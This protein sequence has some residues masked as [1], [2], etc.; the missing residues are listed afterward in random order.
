MTSKADFCLLV[1]VA[2]IAHHDLF[3]VEFPKSAL[4][5]WGSN[6]AVDKNPVMCAPTARGGFRER[7]VRVFPQDML[8]SIRGFHLAQRIA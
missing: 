1:V 5:P 4:V 8:P 3:F 2:Y 6:M 7:L